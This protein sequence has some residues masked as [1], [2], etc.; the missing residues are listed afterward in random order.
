MNI[1]KFLFAIFLPAVGVGLLENK[2]REA[3]KKEEKDR[4]P[5]LEPNPF[6]VYYK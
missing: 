2:E 1:K 6:F 3:K 5:H 4:P